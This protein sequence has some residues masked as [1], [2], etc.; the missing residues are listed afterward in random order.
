MAVDYGDRNE[1]GVTADDVVFSSAVVANDTVKVT[2]RKNAPVFLS[3]LFGIESLTARAT[4]R[5]ASGCS[6]QPSRRR[7]SE[8]ISAR[9]LVHPVLECEPRFN[10]PTELEFD[11][12]G[13]GAF[14]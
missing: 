9:M 10:E 2:A 7:R 12:V 6:D 13:P 14:A 8:W 4:A 5:R 11:K 3:R 1:G